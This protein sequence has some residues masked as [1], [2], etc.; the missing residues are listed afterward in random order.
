MDHPLVKLAG[1]ISWDKIE[2]EFSGLFSEQGRPSVAIRKIAGMLLLKDMF[3][4]SDE[5]VIERWIENAYWQYFTG[6]AF[7][8]RTAL[9]FILI[10]I[11]YYGSYTR[12]Y[13]LYEH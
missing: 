12:S 6:E 10:I 3:K 7:S 4:E 11:Q 1:E 2:A 8:D 5:S 9:P 13:R